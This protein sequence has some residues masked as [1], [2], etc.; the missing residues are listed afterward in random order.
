MIKRITDPNEFFKLCDDINE[1]FSHGEHKD[2]EDNEGHAFDLR[3]NHETIKNS[4]GHPK[5]LAF[6]VFVWG[7]LDNGKYNAIGIFV[8]DKNIKFGEAILT[9]FLWLS[10]NPKAGFKILKEA[11]KLAREKNIKYIRISTSAKNPNTPRY[12]RVYK[13]L[14][15]VKDSTS[16]IGKL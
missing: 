15:F 7:N 9:E 16:F 2:Q 6:D 11:T 8:N 1:L 5:I 12:E 14:G 4:F 13:K 3:H 10:K